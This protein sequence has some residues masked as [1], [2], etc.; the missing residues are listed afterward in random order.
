MTH[1]PYQPVPEPP[2]RSPYL[3]Y[4]IT[5]VLIVLV[6]VFI[7]WVLNPDRNSSDTTTPG[8]TTETTLPGGGT[9]LP[10]ATTT[11]PEPT[12]TTVPETTSTTG[13]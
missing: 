6:I 4:V 1:D 10:D 7:A 11:L 5:G 3:G 8:G 12:S 2:P 9:T 13:G